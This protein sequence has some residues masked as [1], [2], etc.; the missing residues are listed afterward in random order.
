MRTETFSRR[1]RRRT[2]AAAVTSL[3]LTALAGPVGLLGSTPAEAAV[4]PPQPLLYLDAS[5]PASYPGTGT[6]WTDLSGGGNHG[7]IG[8]NGITFN[9]TTQALDFPGGPFGTAWVSLGG[10]LDDFSN[11]ITIEFEGEFGATRAPWERIFDWAAGISQTANVIAVGQEAATNELFY[12]GNN[13]GADQC[14]TSTGGTALGALGDRTMAKW[15]ITVGDVNGVS[16]CRIYKN[17]IELPTIMALNTTPQSGPVADGTPYPLPSVST[18]SS[19]FLGRSNFPQDNDLEGSIRYIRLYQQPLTPDQVAANTGGP[20]VALFAA[21]APLRLV[22]TR[23]TT[24]LDGGDEIREVQVAG[25]AGV[26]ADATAVALNVTATGSTEAGFASVFPCGTDLPDTSTVNFAAGQTVPNAA[27]VALGDGK[28]CVYANVDT[29]LVLDVNGSYSASEGTGVLST[30]TPARLLD[31]RDSGTKVAAGVPAELTVAGVGDIPADA[32]AVVVNV[33]VTEPDA[34]GYMTL[35]PCGT[36]APLASNLNYVAGQTVPNQATVAVGTDGKICMVSTAATHVVVDADAAFGP[37]GNG[38]FEPL[39]PAR[40]VDTRTTGTPLTANEPFE[41]TVAGAGGA[42]ADAGAAI[43][44]VTVT[45]PAAAGYVTVYP[46]GVTPPLASNL[47]VVAGQTVANAVTVAL[48]AG[49]ACVVST[50]AT[51]IVVDVNGD[52]L[53]VT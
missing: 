18:R 19:N 30:M 27:T 39:T 8:G 5:N 7:T 28:V 22:D 38:V 53:T 32:E 44:N 25:V 21:Q 23:D 34:D 4:T 3:T 42:S 6:T 50:V 11:G 10:T 36:D 41:V 24:A 47:N 31:T 1:P 16:K 20:G 49:K 51:D 2:F 40:L 45:N 48:T 12:A 14:V 9:P 35:Y 17:G 52:F 33:T 43:L 13:G 37:T 26:P 29:H 15:V 46:C